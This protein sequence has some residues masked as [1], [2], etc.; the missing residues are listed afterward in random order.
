MVT[1]WLLTSAVPSA[2]S[3]VCIWVSRKAEGAKAWEKPILAAD[4]VYR[5]GTPE[6]KKAGLSGIDEDNSG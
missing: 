1:W 5:L 2:Q 6:A 4:G 3:D